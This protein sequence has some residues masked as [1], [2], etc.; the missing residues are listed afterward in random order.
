MN[1]L[2]K[3]KMTLFVENYRAF[4]G[5]FFWQNNIM[6]RLSAL[7]Y[8]GRGQRLNLRAVKENAEM[9]KEKM[10]PFSYFRGH[11]QLCL[12][13][14]LS[15]QA[16]R[17]RLLED[18]T[19]VYELLKT[20]KF[21]ASDY[22]VVAAYQIASSAAA[23]DFEEIAQRAEDFYLGMK[24]EHRFLT[25]H[26][27]Y[28][29]AVLLALS[30]KEVDSGVNQIESFFQAMKAKFRS[31]DS[32][33]NLAQVLALGDADSDAVDRVLALSEQFKQ[34]KLRLDRQLTLPSLGILAL[35]PVETEVLVA[36]VVEVYEF[37]RNQKG[38]KVLSAG[39]QELQLFATALAAYH[40]AEQSHD[41][42]MS[43]TLSTGITNIIVAQQA[44]I[45]VVIATSASAAAS[46]S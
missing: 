7:L 2:L 18:T 42:L 4:E 21:M 20:K 35:L 29:F 3:S 44:A 41:K 11:T 15:M 5:E 16:N 31:G 9:I 10:G 36:D 14:L 32:V 6:K 27:D 38:F 12:A 37:L 8:A 13:T 22:L 17:Q 25:G 30:E 23:G 40:Y 33:L 39:V 46:N 1:P 28:I 26:N 45:A 24:A 19:V 34:K 43:S